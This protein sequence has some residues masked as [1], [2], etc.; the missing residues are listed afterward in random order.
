MVCLPILNL[1]TTPADIP[2]QTPRELDSSPIQKRAEDITKCWEAFDGQIHCEWAK[3]DSLVNPKEAITMCWEAPDGQ[4]YCESAADLSKRSDSI[5][6]CWESAD[7]QI[8]CQYAKR[9]EV[10]NDITKCRESPHGQIH[11]EWSS[12]DPEPV[13]DVSHHPYGLLSLSHSLFL[14]KS[15]V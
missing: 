15:E 8:H 10:V 5:T 1:L 2:Y 6:K 7:G 13:A 4:I 3:H 9:N 11:C 14:K 12:R